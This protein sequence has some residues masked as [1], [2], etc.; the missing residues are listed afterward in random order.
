MLYLEW[1]KV[2]MV[3]SLITIWVVIGVVTSIAVPEKTDFKNCMAIML[4][5]ESDIFLAL[6]SIFLTVIMPSGLFSAEFQV[7][8]V[9]F[10]F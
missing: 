1:S 4:V 7:R 5:V 10:V 6:F 3:L 2:A 8:N 9:L